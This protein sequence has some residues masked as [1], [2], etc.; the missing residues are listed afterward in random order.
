MFKERL[1]RSQQA[2]IRKDAG[3]YKAKIIRATRDDHGY[4]NYLIE[5]E[6]HS[7]F[8]FRGWWNEGES[9]ADIRWLEE[10]VNGWPESVR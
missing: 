6:D 1:T 4:P 7:G 8:K 3:L 9:A 10:H 2:Q 5:A